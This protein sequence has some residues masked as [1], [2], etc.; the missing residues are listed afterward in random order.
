MTL[1]ALLLTATTLAT[2]PAPS[3]DTAQVV[4][5]IHTVSVDL[6]YL[7]LTHRYTVSPGGTIED[8]WHDMG[9]TYA[10]AWSPQPVHDMQIDIGAAISDDGEHLDLVVHLTRQV[11]KEAPEVLSNTTLRMPLE[12]LDGRMVSGGLLPR[13]VP[14]AKTKSRLPWVEAEDGR[15]LSYTVFDVRVSPVD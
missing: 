3:A 14:T 4:W 12:E 5:P 7:G 2:E 15:G 11:P 9:G 8:V 13:L 6:T 10:P 1:L